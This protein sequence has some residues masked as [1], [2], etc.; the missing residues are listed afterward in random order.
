MRAML[1][2][3]RFRFAL[4]MVILFSGALFA[5]SGTARTT[6]A[7]AYVVPV[8]EMAVA[9][10]NISPSAGVGTVNSALFGSDLISP[11]GDILSPALQY[12]LMSGPY[13][14]AISNG[15][16]IVIDTSKRE[17]VSTIKPTEK[18]SRIEAVAVSPDGKFIYA[19]V[20]WTVYTNDNLGGY[21]S[22]YSRLVRLNA[23]NQQPID[24][25]KVDKVRPEHLAVSPD[26]RVYL[27]FQE[28][29]YPDHAGMG[30]YDFSAG[31]SWYQG[32]NSDY[33]LMNFEFAGNGNKVYYAGWWD[34]P[35]VYELDWAANSVHYNKMPGNESNS[36]EYV[37][38][39]AT[40]KGGGILYTAV[41]RNKGISV[42]N[43]ADRL[44]KIIYT[45]YVP[46]AL[47]SSKDGEKLFV[48]GYF[49][50]SGNK[51]VYII[52]KYEGLNMVGP[53]F[54]GLT[55]FLLS[56]KDAFQYDSLSF[57]APPA[58]T[59]PSRMAVSADGKYGYI[60]TSSG[61]GT[62]ASG[63]DGIIVYDLEY[64]NQVKTIS[65]KNMASDI[66][67]SSEKIV[68]SP[69]VDL[70][71][72]QQFA[73]SMPQLSAMDDYAYVKQFYPE[74]GS[75]AK[76]YAQD[77]FVVYAAFTEKLDNSTVNS[78]TFWLTEKSGANVAGKAR[79]ATAIAIFSPEAQLKPGTDYVAHLSKSIKSKDGKPL[80]ADVAWNFTT[81]NTSA[82][83]GAQSPNSTISFA[84]IREMGAFSGGLSLPLAAQNNSSKQNR[85]RNWLSDD[86]PA[87]AG[88]MPGSLSDW[89]NKSGQTDN[90]TGSQAGNDS[91]SQNGGTQGR[92][93]GNAGIEGDDN[94]LET[95]SDGNNGNG[96]RGDGN[97][98]SVNGSKANTPALPEPKAS[99]N[100]ENGRIDDA[101]TTAPQNPQ[102]GPLAIGPQPPAPQKG[103]FDGIIDFFRSLFGMG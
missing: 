96:I 45:D 2:S 50:D 81:K 103:F 94:P 9:A 78:S 3:A 34:Y 89:A 55:D 91:G 58:N 14:Y 60:M 59:Y 85:S 16:I 86:G 82:Q 13:A 68:Y 48:I 66:A 93:G 92:T 71:F 70:S 53:P 56:T 7:T 19:A 52:H 79:S 43:T 27:G 46:V 28:G 44:M 75:F 1:F 41:N 61:D 73:L 6:P 97:G 49:Y 42:M 5:V 102:P 20:A 83:G 29:G 21:T 98:S 54:G 77:F 67:I 37:R 32:Y 15:N 100:D 90:N 12:A 80:Y 84:R 101:N 51:P 87:L 95:V 22:Y 25:F 63:G 62:S 76:D 18:D 33:M 11:T 74:K 30:V 31:K 57:V 35:A 26:G 10:T 4:A 88:R 8:L 38:S 99:G 69:P 17:T 23:S 72:A 39:I 65:G 47:A 64:M 40:A 24:Y 36:Y